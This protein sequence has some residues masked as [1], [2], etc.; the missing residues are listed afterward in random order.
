MSCYYSC[1]PL[2]LF[3]KLTFEL[4]VCV[5]VCVAYVCYIL[6][7]STS[8]LSLAYNETTL[9]LLTL[10][11]KLLSDVKR[12]LSPSLLVP[13]LDTH[14]AVIFIFHVVG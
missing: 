6:S 2:N 12:R 9:R 10:N 7:S 3:S 8:S 14:L 13:L 4:F 5:C 1:R 11:V